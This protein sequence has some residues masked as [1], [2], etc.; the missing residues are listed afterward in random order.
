VALGDADAF[1][2]A[3]DP[4]IVFGIG[5]NEVGRFGIDEVRERFQAADVFGLKDRRL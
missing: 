3:G 4:A 1:H 5:P 2:R